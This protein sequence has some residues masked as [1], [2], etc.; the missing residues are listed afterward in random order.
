LAGGWLVGITA[1]HSSLSET[2]TK[3]KKKKK[4]IHRINKARPVSIPERIKNPIF[5]K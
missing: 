3:K 5:K 2:V 4:K 1:H